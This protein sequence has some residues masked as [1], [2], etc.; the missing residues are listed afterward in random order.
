[1]TTN[2][3]EIKA[4]V[5][6]ELSPE[7]MT[8]LIATTFKGLNPL[9]VEKAIV[10][11]MMRGFHFDDFLQ[12][13]VYA[14]PF[15][16]GYSLVTS[17]DYARKLGMKG[18]IVGTSAPI[19]DEKDGKIISCTVTVKRKVDDYIGD[20]SAT[21][22]FEEYNTG[23][24]QWKTKPRTMIAKVAEMHALRKACPEE[25]SQSYSEEELQSEKEKVVLDTKEFED[26]L[27]NTKS[28]EELRAVFGSLSGEMKKLLRPLADKLKAQY[29]NTQI[30]K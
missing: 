19:Y 23:R 14:I 21:V 12:K 10:E 3:I 9:N 2:I 8:A 27:N 15:G 26:K 20:Y 16:D 6:K 30:S 4:Q 22:F 24:N 25:L 18:G 13:N 28:L 11:G 7:I 17:I 1:M 29:E 5:K